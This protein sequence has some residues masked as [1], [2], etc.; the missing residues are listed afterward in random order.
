VQLNFTHY[1]VHASLG[2]RRVEIRRAGRKVAG[3]PVTIG[4]AGSE[5]PPGRFGITDALAGN[6]LG[7]WYGCC[8]LA[9]SGHQPRTPEGWLGGDRIAIHGT[10]GAVGA[11]LSAGCLRATNLDMVQLFSRVPLGAP[12]VITA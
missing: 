5:T 11:A 2:E 1:S 9:L 6:K 8:I 7:P 3:F 4:R 10:P 12:V